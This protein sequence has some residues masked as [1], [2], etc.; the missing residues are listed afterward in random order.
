M[1]SGNDSSARTTVVRDDV[2]ET[3]ALSSDRDTKGP[4]SRNHIQDW[5]LNF[6]RVFGAGRKEKH[7][8]IFAHGSGWVEE[9]L[10]LDSASAIKSFWLK[11]PYAVRSQRWP[12]MMLHCL[13]TS[14]RKTLALLHGL[15]HETYMSWIMVTD[16]LLFLKR[17]YLLDMNAD[18]AMKKLFNAALSDQRNTER[19]P[20][21]FMKKR[22]LEIFLEEATAD[23]GRKLWHDLRATLSEPSTS[24]ILR[25]MDFFTKVGDIDQA[26]HCLRSIPP[27]TLAASEAQVLARCT[28]LLKLDTVQKKGTS[29]N[30]NILPRM[31]ESGIK[32]SLIIHNIVLKNA[33]ESGM[34]GVGWDLFRFMQEQGLPT[35]ARTYLALLKDAFF[36]QDTLRLNELFSAIHQRS[37]LYQNGR[38]VAYT[39]NIVRLISY[40]N[41]LSPVESFS[42]MLPMYTRAFNT[43][44]LKRLRL[45]MDIESSHSDASLPNPDPG[46]LAFTVWSYIL[47]Q[48]EPN[49]VNTLWHCFKRLVEAGDPLIV[50]MSRLDIVYNGFAVFYSRR[51]AGLPHCVATVQ[52]MLDTGCCKP[53]ARTWSI[54][55]LAFF[56][57]GRWS[58]SEKVKQIMR[59]RGVKLDEATRT[60]IKGRLSLLDMTSH[61]RDV[62]RRLETDIEPPEEYRM[63]E[64]DTALPPQPDEALIFTKTPTVSS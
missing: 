42:N 5:E 17:V 51:G 23:E 55:L 62:L 20:L 38:I 47:S 13:T 57:H 30:F 3:P 56:K 6:E 18:T 60:L 31:L 64:V 14:A 48:R 35:D 4:D 7:S 29:H 32:P 9:L 40:Q 43:E 8:D 11:N 49:V 44:P 53:T 15:P 34:S 46:T 25:F 58:A 28:N 1:Q 12:I 59:D 16:C 41:K 24:T 33:F 22:H 2:L 61:A 39:L 21:S 63:P 50:G 19:W 45:I 26:L 36:Q 10:R 27:P 52:H 54:L 37:D